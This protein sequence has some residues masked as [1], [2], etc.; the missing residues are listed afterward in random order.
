MRDRIAAAVL[1]VLIG[2]LLSAAVGVADQSPPAPGAG[3]GY[4]I[5]AHV[6]A[7]LPCTACHTT[8]PPR[9]VSTDTCLRCHGGSYDKLAAQTAADSPNPHQSH[10]GEV[11]CANCHHVHQASENLC[12]QCHTDFDINVP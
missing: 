7:G 3:H 4:L 11:P 2:C 9:L 6:A 12:A 1:V 10:Q 5:D 8:A